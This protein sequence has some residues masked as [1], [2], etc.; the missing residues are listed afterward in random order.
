MPV[1]FRAEHA[2]YRWLQQNYP[3]IT[4]NYSEDGLVNLRKH[5]M[6]DNQRLKIDLSL[7]RRTMLALLAREF[8]YPE[9]PLVDD[10]F[11]LFYRMRH[12]VEFYDDV[13]DV[14]KRL[15]PE[16]RMGSITNGNACA[17]LTPL[18]EYFEHYVNASDVMVRKPDAGIFEAFCQGMQ[19]RPELCLYVGDDPVYDVRGA[20]D[21]GMRTV[22]INR[23]GSEWPEDM[24]AADAEVQNL[25]GLLELPGLLQT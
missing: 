8:D 20:R 14:L 18:A 1:I 23:E 6:Q 25:Y 16:Y 24:A 19:V 4:S 17:A 15:Q 7:M 2:T 5:L 11:E 22:W 12:Q 3:R 21:A 13:F 9:Q 10:G